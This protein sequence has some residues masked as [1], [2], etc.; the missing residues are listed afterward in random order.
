MG[1]YK[2]DHGNRQTR[3]SLLLFT[4]YRFCVI[5]VALE[6][7]MNVDLKTI[8][9]LAIE[10]EPI[11]GFSFSCDSFRC[12]QDVQNVSHASL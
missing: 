2:S 12:R 11:D 8:H 3:S 4:C 7:N 5:E 10:R 9:A 1:K 6:L